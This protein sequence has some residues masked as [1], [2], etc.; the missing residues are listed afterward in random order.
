MKTDKSG[1]S[2]WRRCVPCMSKRTAT[3][4]GTRLQQVK[5]TW[6]DCGKPSKVYWV[7]PLLLTRTLIQ[8][9]TLLHFLKI[10][11]M[12]C[13]HLP[14]RHDTTVKCSVQTWTDYHWME[15]RYQWSSWEAHQLCIEQDV[16][17][18]PISQVADK[19]Y[20]RTA[21]T[22]HLLSVQQITLHWL[23]PAGVQ[24]S[25]CSTASEEKWSWRQWIEGL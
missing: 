12:Q 23:F 8:L 15:Y 4:E 1:W 25:C 13:E 3:T 11:S 18:G 20:A 10:K 6:Q 2:G 14:L 17:T 5:V 21:V 24:G 9:M 22:I 19:G 16:S 7:K